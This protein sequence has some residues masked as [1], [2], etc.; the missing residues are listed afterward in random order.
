MTKLLLF[1]AND[2]S[3][4]NMK[5]QF[6][7]TALLL[8]FAPICGF[9]QSNWTVE[10]R[11]G[12]CFIENQGQY[13]AAESQIGRTIQFAVDRGFGWQ[14]YLSEQSITYHLQR[15]VPE[16]AIPAFLTA[17]EERKGK[18]S[19]IS[20]SVI[21]QEWLNTASPVITAS[22]Q[23]P[24]YFTYSIEEKS[25]WTDYNHV[26]AYEKLFLTHLYSFVTLRYETHKEGGIKYSLLVDPGA[27]VSAIQF[28]WK[29]ATPTLDAQGNI[30]METV[31]G[32]M[33]DHAPIAFYADNESEKI[34]C[35]FTLNGNEV[36]FSLGSYDAS[37]AIVIDPW[38]VNPA[39][40]APFNRSYE[41]DADN[42]GNVFV[43]GGGMGFNCKKYNAAG[44]LQWTHISPWD[45][46]N[47]WFGELL[48]MPTGES[49][50]TS[51]SA[52]KIRKLTAAG[53]TT[54]TNN[55][56]FFNLDEYWTLSLN[57]DRT[58]LISGGT[59]IIG[60][61]SPQGHLFDLNLT[62][63]N[64]MAGSPYNVSAVGMDEVRALNIGA[65]GILYLMTNSKVMGMSPAFGTIFSIANTANY[66]Y[67]SPTYKCVNVQGV[68]NIDAST[69]FLYTHMGST[70]Y[71]RDLNTGAVISST[72]IT[73]G[74]FTGGFFGTGNT[75]GGLVVDDCGNVF[76]GSTA[77][78]YK[79][80]A[81]LNL[82][83]S[84]ATTGNVYDLTIAAGPALI[85]GGAALLTS[86]TSL[87]PCAPKTITCPILP[88][89]LTSFNSLC[90]NQRTLLK[91][92][93][94]SE[95]SLD[96]FEVQ[97]TIDG[98]AW[99]KIATLPAKGDA[100]SLTD[101]FTTDNKPGAIYYRLQMVDENGTHHLSHIVAAP[102]C[103][104]SQP[105]F[106]VWP[107][108]THDE[109]NVS[110]SE[111]DAE[112]IAEIWSVDG[113][114][115]ERVELPS[116][117][118]NDRRSIAVSLREFNAGIYFIRVKSATS[119]KTFKVVLEF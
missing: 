52:A 23:R 95:T 4:Q 108:V 49:F 6:L 18:R 59:R 97:R 51:G 61:V 94:A 3:H 10:A 109:I 62:N 35:A 86:N 84:V 16:V 39:L 45:T 104:K 114:L 32:E 83:G 76:V 46:S 44:T 112:T 101:Y 41:V 90:D 92:Q 5:L 79:Y 63:G 74:G 56:P 54:F 118:S 106:E 71:K 58:K 119:E 48:V 55:G 11:E 1:N 110:V 21:T 73:G 9:S 75:A 68:N 53:G 113:Q 117:L 77:A 91:W 25:G 36:G 69:S 70:L 96:R 111:T 19:L 116:T 64:Q 107:T 88:L 100:H 7:A 31:Y 65:S 67:N 89:E 43:F 30:R 33:I 13:K 81:N 103:E 115:L 26:R 85:I 50:I 28:R 98:E 22:N 34:S 60:L 93:T 72:P 57:C 47:A 42:A 15:T 80:D 66:P 24:D 37:R 102:S 105:Q 87:T 38:T 82:L 27:D 17:E 99:E 40:P 8:I 29:G 14:A 78:V 12:Q 20:E 2:H